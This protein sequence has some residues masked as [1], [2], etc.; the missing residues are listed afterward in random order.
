LVIDLRIV[1][2]CAAVVFA[3]L[4]VV[5]PAQ[6]PLWTSLGLAAAL[7][8]EAIERTLFFAAVVPARMPGGIRA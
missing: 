5:L 8:G 1:L 4:A 3:Y 2:A 6:A 7:L